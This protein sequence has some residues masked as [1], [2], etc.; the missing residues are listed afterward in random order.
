MRRLSFLAIF[1]GVLWALYSDAFQGRFEIGGLSSRPFRR[2]IIQRRR[3]EHPSEVR[4]VSAQHTK[5]RPSRVCEITPDKLP[6]D[7][8]VQPGGE[9]IIIGRLRA[10]PKR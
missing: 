7:M 5:R 1:I 3:A 4:T 8:L 10:M 2:S 9:S 6:A